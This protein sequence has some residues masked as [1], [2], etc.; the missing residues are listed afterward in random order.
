M[1]NA[2]WRLGGGCR[3]SQI[4]VPHNRVHLRFSSV[5]HLKNDL[6]APK[7]EQQYVGSRIE[8]VSLSTEFFVFIFSFHLPSSP[9]DGYN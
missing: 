3:F 7:V 9:Q 2:E 5:T 8:I 6:I 1:S 4:F